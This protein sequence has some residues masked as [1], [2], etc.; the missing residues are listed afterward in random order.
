M[1]LGP[2]HPAVVLPLQ[3]WGLPLSALV[4]GALAPD[5]PVFLPVPVEYATTHSA[6][7][8]WADVA[9]GAALLWL[10]DAFVRDAVVDLAPVLRDRRPPHAPLDGRAWLIAPVALA[11]G[12]ASHVLWDSVTHDW[13]FV[14]E[15]V[16]L[17]REGYG[18][19]PAYR[20]LQHLSTVVGSAVVAA[21]C[22]GRLRAAA[23]VP[24][25][26]S[27]RRPG[28]WLAAPPLVGAVVGI[29]LVDPEAGVGA[30]LVTLLVVALAW[31]VARRPGRGP[32]D[33]V[34][35]PGSRRRRRG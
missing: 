17:L 19:W 13:G 6:A 21:F 2:A 32:D 5:T 1:P 4:V 27:V 31:R 23:V 3:R 34:R 29:G 24:R 18:P 7:G 28:L 12:S 30:G 26:A 14:V 10:W 25:P 35:G 9:L 11:V 15:E 16:A 8:L 22:V 20:W 33:A